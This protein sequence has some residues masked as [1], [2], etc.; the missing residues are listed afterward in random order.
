MGSVVVLREEVAPKRQT[1]LRRPNRELR[2]REHLTAREVERLIGAA[3]GNRCGHRDRTMIL[4]AFRHARPG[5][6]RWRV[7]PVGP[8]GVAPTPKTALDFS[9]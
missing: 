9:R 3:K 2:T 5:R 1:P 4:I 6:G 7:I 8:S